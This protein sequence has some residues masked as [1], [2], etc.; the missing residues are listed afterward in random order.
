MSSV[1]Y[2]RGVD[3]SQL[4]K[5][6]LSGEFAS[7]SLDKSD[8]VTLKRSYVKP[9]A[10]G[11]NGDSPSFTYKEEGATVVVYTTN[12]DQYESKKQECLEKGESEHALCM[13][14]GQRCKWCRE[15]IK[16]NPVGIP[17]S[18]F[19]NRVTDENVIH[20]EGAYCTFECAFAGLKNKNMDDRLGRYRNSEAIMRHLFWLS[21]PEHVLIAAPDWELHEI[22][23]GTLSSEA[24]HS[25]HHRY[26]PINN[27]FFLPCKQ[28]FRQIIV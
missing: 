9:V 12:C 28:M 4:L 26:T 19:K 5:E 15:E 3:W 10:R 16:T 23:Q 17:V 7:D 27:W 21:H 14:P 13:I 20:M 24:F 11:K 22:N 1:L 2:L 8:V 18:Y 6:Y 25:K